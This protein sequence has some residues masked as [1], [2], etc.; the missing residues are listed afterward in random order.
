MNL[1]TQ[2][3]GIG[4]MKKTVDNIQL[5]ESATIPLLIGIISFKESYILVVACWATGIFRSHF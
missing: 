5:I 4:F 3:S 1:I 2:P